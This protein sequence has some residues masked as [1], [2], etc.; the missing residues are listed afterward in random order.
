MPTFDV[1]IPTSLLVDPKWPERGQEVIWV[2]SLCRG[3]LYPL[4]YNVNC[5]CEFLK[6]QQGQQRLST[7]SGFTGVFYYDHCHGQPSRPASLI[8]TVF[9]FQVEGE[10]HHLSPVLSWKFW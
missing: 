9:R 2:S 3:V 10:V 1:D 5:G 6:R 7:T 4:L 8:L